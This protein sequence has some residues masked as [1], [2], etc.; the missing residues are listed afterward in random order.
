MYQKPT[1]EFISINP[2]GVVAA[3]G[4]F[5][6]MSGEFTGLENESYQMDAETISFD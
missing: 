4:I 1:T 2:E 5:L 6:L 3:S